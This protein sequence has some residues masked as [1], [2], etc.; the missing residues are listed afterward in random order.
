MANGRFL[1]FVLTYEGK[2]FR[3]Q[4]TEILD[5]ADKLIKGGAVGVG[6]TYSANY[7]QTLKIDQTYAD[8]KWNTQTGGANQASVMSEMESLEQGQT[9]SHLQGKMRIVPITTMTY[10]DFGKLTLDEVIGNDMKH[11]ESLL[12]QGWHILGWINQTGSSQYAV[13]GGE[14]KKW[15]GKHPTL[16]L[17]PQQSATIQTT[18]E[19]FH[20]AYP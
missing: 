12:Q 13:G 7:Q 1:N 11:I 8:G 2:T 6:I 9:Y 10:S 14:S 18:L 4:A 5:E 3:Q 16:A 17:S 15:Y 20:K 19:G